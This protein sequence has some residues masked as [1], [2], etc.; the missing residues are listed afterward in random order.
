M[1]TC[2]KIHRKKRRLCIGSMDEQITLEVRSIQSPWVSSVDAD[3]VDLGESFTNQRLV[4]AAVN[5]TR[6]WQTFDGTNIANAV[7]HLFYIRYIPNVTFEDWI[8]YKGERYDIVDVENLDERN[9]FYVLRANKR[10]DDTI[11]VNKA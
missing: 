8:L 3:G 6:G 11:E 7:T 2:G 5:T 10:G 4:W 9:E 1:A